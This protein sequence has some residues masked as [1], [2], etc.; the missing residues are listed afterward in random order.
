MIY[1]IRSADKV[2]CKIGYTRDNETLLKRFNTI[3]TNVPMD[4]YLAASIDGEVSKEQSIHSALN[5][6]RTRGEWYKE[7]HVFDYIEY[8]MKR[9]DDICLKTIA[10]KTAMDADLHLVKCRNC[11]SDDA[12]FEWCGSIGKNNYYAF[13]IC[14]NCSYATLNTE[15]HYKDEA[16]LIAAKM[17]REQ[18]E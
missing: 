2:Y 1:L 18:N 6:L 12:K 11:G 8:Q 4:V 14:K 7:S 15:G 5:N 13:V 3:K 10:E 16:L 9:Q 17:W